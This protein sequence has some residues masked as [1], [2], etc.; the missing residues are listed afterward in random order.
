MKKSRILLLAAA[1]LIILIESV[2]AQVD[3]PSVTIEAGV[4]NGTDGGYILQVEYDFPE[5]FHQ[6]FQENFFKFEILSPGSVT[7]GAISYPEGLK[8]GEVI[9]YYGKTV[10]KADLSGYRPGSGEDLTVKASW[11]LCNEDGMCLFPQ[12][13]EI[14]AAENFSVSTADTPSQAGAS[15][16]V[17]NILFFLLL[18]FLGGL[19]LNVMPC[20][21]PVLSIKALSLVKQG[22][23][24]RK[25]ILASSLLYTAGVI[26]SLLALA[27]VIII[28]KASGEQVGWGFQFQNRSFVIALLTIIFVFAL[29]LFDV[30]SISAPVMKT[31]APVG[32]KSSA[33][34]HFFSGVIAVLLAT[35]CT[36][37]F[38][39][40]AAGFAFSQPAPVILA[41]FFMVGLGLAFPFIIIG[42]VPKV[43]S[44]LPKPGAWMDTFREIMGFLLIGTSV[45]LIDV[46]LYQSTQ[47]FLTK[48]LIYLTA[49]SIAAWLYGKFTAPGA[50][51][52]KGLTGLA[53]AV[54]IIAASA[55]FL[56]SGSNDTGNSDSAGVENI[57]NAKYEGW[58][59]FTP[60]T[61]YES[62]GGDRPVFVA[63]GAK[64]CMT[65]RTNESTV[66]FTDEV[67]RFFEENEAILIHGDYTNE[68]PEITEWMK[69]FGRAG[70][71]FYTW[72]PAG[73][74]EAELLPEIISRRM[75]T[76]LVE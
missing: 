72:Y 69:E 51:R 56:F 70:V 58:L 3:N 4:I 21:L 52:R 26:I 64:W 41:V 63:F 5:G 49:V 37:P 65:C 62:I 11:Q 33:G 7:A 59:E 29:S 1:I 53:V 74:F 8:E 40:T 12:S 47:G 28:I 75:I 46:L 36:A 17:P 67:D 2:S 50:S 20:V 42:F 22:G 73:S 60:E 16:A 18:S 45:W 9:N 43:V 35:P 6:T 71:P 34:S 57:K 10:I 19:L 31:G 48:L 44:R 14:T 55:T 25:Q 61:V 24:N 76:N 23:E 27:V 39:G 66:L 32:G 54:V 38:L 15:G 68:S 13:K 30:F